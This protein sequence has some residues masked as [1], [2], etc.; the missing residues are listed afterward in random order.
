[1]SRDLI[2]E[3]SYEKIA[4]YDPATLSILS[5]ALENHGFFTVINH[6]IKDNLL[7]ASY[8]LAKKF[9]ELDESIKTNYSRPEHG[10]ARG[11]YSIW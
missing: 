9:F 6:G 11:L 2:P 3:L 10:G 1:M 8:D 5:G 4:T 7:D